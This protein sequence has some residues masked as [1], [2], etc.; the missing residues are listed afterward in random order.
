MKHLRCC[1]VIAALC[2]PSLACN[3]QCTSRAQLNKWERGQFVEAADSRRVEVFAQFLSTPGCAEQMASSLIRLG[4]KIDFMDENSG[5]AL[6]KIPR[7]RLLETLDIAGI[8]Y[9]DTSSDDRM[10][11]EDPVAKIPQS[12]RKAEPVPVIAIPDPRVAAELPK[13][14]PYFAAHEIGLDALW[15]QFPE[16]DGRGTTAAVLDEGLDLLHPALQEARDAN[17]KLIPKIVDEVAYANQEEDQNWVQL[18]EPIKTQ[19][20]VFEANGAQWIVPEDGVYRFGI[21]RREFA[22]GE[23]AMSNTKK[24]TIAVG[25]LWSEQRGRVWVNTNGDG[26]FKDQRGLSDF[27][28]AH[29]IDW[30]GNKEGDDDNRVPFGVKIDSARHAVYITI[31]NGGHGMAVSGSLAANRLTGGL[32]DGA[33]PGAQLIDAR[34]YWL[35]EL[36]AI[37]QLAARKDAGV[38]SLSAGFAR[39]GPEGPLEG[40]EDFQRHVAERMV[41]VYDKPMTCVCTANGLIS[42]NDYVSGEMLRRNRQASGP[43][44][45]AVHDFYYTGRNW[46]LVNSVLAPSGQLNTESRYMPVSVE[47]PDRK[48]RVYLDSQLDSPA[49]TGYYIGANESP[50]IPV[51][52]GVIMDLISEAK[53][54]HVRYSTSRLNQAIFASARI[55]PGVPLYQQGYGLIQADGAWKQLA[56]MAKADDPSNVTLTSFDVSQVVGSHM[57]KIDG[58]YRETT[59][60]GGMLRGEV[61]VTRHGGHAGVRAYSF[62]LRGNDGTYTLLTTKAPSLQNEP[63]RISFKAAVTSGFHV[64]FIELI[65]ETAGVV[66]QQVPVSL[67]V[68]DVS[69]I[70]A[71]S[72]ERYTAIIPPRQTRVSLFELGEEVQAAHFSAQ[73]PFAGSRWHSLL[74]MPGFKCDCD[75]TGFIRKEPDGEP[76]DRV[77]HVGPMELFESLVANQK[78]GIHGVSWDN[79]GL[80]AEYETPYMSPAPTVSITGTV[81]V[82]KYA[83]AIEKGANDALSITNKLA[84]VDGQVELYDATLETWGLTGTGSHGSG[85]V[86]RRLPSGLAEWRLR[87]TLNAF[88]QEPADIYVLNCSGKNG[89]VVIAQQAIS[90]TGKTLTVEKPQAGSWKVVVRGR[91]QLQTPTTYTI[92]EALLVPAATAIEQG[93]NKHASGA[94]WTVALPARASDAQYV[95]FRIAG[96]PG[97][98]REKNGLLIAMTPLDDIAP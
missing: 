78:A 47:F 91:D 97:N 49:P 23:E 59:A 14:G 16:A 17:A 11:Y 76:V 22:L 80:H 82:S 36:P 86:E 55:I 74:D 43:Y 90:A 89:C 84:E 44:K 98:E 31:A 95:A 69:E 77:R 2:I 73:I 41:E 8:A 1:A 45:E 21:F 56:R 94:T 75:T 19:N 79:R 72:V 42:V 6:V 34:G 51:V 5:Y 24:F 63:L 88:S 48:R 7:E 52:A 13:D 3:A 32:Y 15:Q 83:V 30:F 28:I 39:S 71:P 26:S 10:Y 54:Q 38:I 33:A 67:K 60:P 68:P 50:T 35:M 96:T 85:E 40:R 37:L 64:A 29:E 9:A 93:E 58:Y 62:G 65:D 46:G 61:W 87:V 81:T 12:Q 66:M 27:A 70:V 20:G 92:R 4:A 53:Q 57:E 25:V 18:G